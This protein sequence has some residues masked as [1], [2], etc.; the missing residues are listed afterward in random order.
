[1]Q[2]PKLDVPFRGLDDVVQFEQEPLDTWLHH[3]TIYKAFCDAAR[4]FAN[5]T[6]LVVQAYGD[7][8]GESVSYSYSDL[9]ARTNQAGNMFLSAGLEDGETVSA[10]LPQSAEA[11]FTLL[12]AESVGIVNAVNPMLA[13]MH[14]HGIMR[15]A[16]TKILVA[17][18]PDQNPEIW[19][20]VCYLI[21]HMPD[22]KA[23]FVTGD[24]SVCD[25]EKIRSF[26]DELAKQPSD[27]IANLRLRGLD[28][29]IGYYHTGGTTGVPKLV[30][31][32]NRMQLIQA[33]ST[34]YIVGQTEKDKVIAGLPLFHI[35]GSVIGGIVPLLAGVT[36]HIISPLGYR[37]PLLIGNYWRLIEKF[38]ITILGTVPT[39]LSALLNIPVGG[40]D[41]SS[42]RIGI[43]GGSATPVE[44]L[45]AITELSGVPMMEGYGMTE[46]ASYSTFMPR[47]AAPRFGSIGVR[48]PYTQIKAVHL[49]N[50]G[51]F[52][53]D[54]DTDE[55]GVIVMKGACIMPGYVQE[56]HN[57][58]AFVA[59]GW[60]NSGDLG[61]IDNDGYI[62]LTGRAK[63][64]IIRS[65]HN[66]DPALIEEP[67]HEHPSVELAAAIG[68][69]DNYTGEMPIAYVQLKP[70]MTATVEELKDFARERITERAANPA[71]IHLLETM[72]LTGVGK[73][74]KPALREMAAREVFDAVL[75]DLDADFEIKMDNSPAYGLTAYVYVQ[76][77]ERK[78]IASEI[79]HRLGAFTLHHEVKWVT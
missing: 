3:K 65:G 60:L 24:G 70:G 44:V 33:T 36:I 72:P 53:R 20:K 21:D 73:I 16:N 26:S 13:Q 32:T 23:V 28:D 8:L 54:A 49:D 76:G 7:P 4:K 29:M 41:I 67:L 69:P 58:N 27:K 6:A 43:T 45:K 74:F 68:R 64:L 11:F 42:L 22:L 18:G 61:R 38:G 35:S 77:A 31:H 46:V 2:T 59:D 30:P 12:G 47:D 55:I 19:E 71:E 57:K 50:K 5:K 62:W 1:M 37:D 39:V 78:D 79:T 14:I 66:L 51:D 17:P 75:A 40:A 10:L 52:L 25:G 9:L 56:Q 34:A 48:Q 15:A 63:D